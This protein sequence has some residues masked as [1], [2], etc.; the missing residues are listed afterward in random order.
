MEWGGEVYINKFFKEILFNEDG[1]VKGYLIWGL[2]GVFDEVIIVD[3]YVFVMLVDFLKIMVL[4][5][6]REYFEFK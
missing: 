5:F 6:W 4:V 3:L 2:D 1:F